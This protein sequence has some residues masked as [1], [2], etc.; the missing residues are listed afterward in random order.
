M[1]RLDVT[2]VEGQRK[3]S[4]NDVEEEDRWMKVSLSGEDALY[5]WC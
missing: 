3:A 5:Y 4:K 2:E 1:N